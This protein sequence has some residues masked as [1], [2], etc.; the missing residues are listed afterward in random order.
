M[1]GNEVIQLLDHLRN[2][3]DSETTPSFSFRHILIDEKFVKAK[4]PKEAEFTHAR[5]STTEEIEEDS[6][7][8][9]SNEELSNE[10][11]TMNLMAIGNWTEEIPSTR[12][13]G[14]D[15][16]AQPS[17]GKPQSVTTQPHTGLGSQDLQVPV[18]DSQNQTGSGSNFNTQPS[19]DNQQPFSSHRGP[20]SPVLWSSL[21]N[22]QPFTG[23]PVTSPTQDTQPSTGIPQPFSSPRGPESPVLRSSVFDT[24]PSTGSPQQE[25]RFSTQD[26]HP[27]IGNTQPLFSNYRG[28]DSPVLRSSVFHTQPAT[29]NPQ[30]FS[31]HRDPDSPVLRSSVSNTQPSTSRL[32]Q[33]VQFSTQIGSRNDQNPQQPKHVVQ[34]HSGGTNF[35][36]SQVSPIGYQYGV[37]Y[38]YPHMPARY[39]YLLPPQMGD[40]ITGQPRY[41]VHPFYAGQAPVG[42]LPYN[43]AHSN[44]PGTDIPTP[45]GAGPAPSQPMSS[46]KGRKTVPKITRE[47]RSS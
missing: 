8:E 43:G 39:G 25:V 45:L 29:G 18:F 32:Q 30:P 47:L 36:Y 33:E 1:K 19:N 44:F 38:A 12:R 17:T 31:N 7:S 6:N 23:N 10:N 42:Y 28:P 37:N 13:A 26:T 15:F 41:N 21:F 34:S 11:P 14:N 20:D 2:H 22:T 5:P 24:Q 35:G 16:D 4:Y 3:Q 27:S 40:P 46:K 9:T